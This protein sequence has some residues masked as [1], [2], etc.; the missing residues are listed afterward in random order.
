MKN[1]LDYPFDPDLVI[2]KKK[3]IK[4]ELLQ[5]V[6]FSD[7]K[8]AI[9][10]G[11]TTSEIKDILELFLLKE[12]IRPEL[13]ESEYNKYYEDIMFPN[14]RLEE[15]NPDLIYFHTTIVNIANFPDLTD[16]QKV[17]EE[18]INSVLSKFR[19]MWITAQKKYKAPIIQNNFELPHYRI[20]GNLDSSDSHGKT[21]FINI[22]NREFAKVAAENKS[23]YLNDIN[24]LSSWIGL[25]KWHDRLFWHS[26]KYAMGYTVIP[27]LSH[28]IASIIISIYGKSKK[29]L[30]LDL[31]N[32]LWGGIIGDDGLNGV[33]IGNETPSAEA[34]TEFQKYLKEIKDRGIILLVCS[35]NEDKNAKEGFNHPDTVLK[36][37][38]FTSFIANWDQKSENIKKVAKQINIGTQ[39]I[40]YIDDNPAEREIVRGNCPDVAVPEIGSDVL[41]FINIIDK[42]GYFE[43]VSISKDD[44]NRTSNYKDNAVRADYQMEFAD[45]GQFLAS[46]NMVAEIDT[47]QPVYMERITQL[48]NKTNQFNLTTKRYTAAE[49][50][51]VYQDPSYI[52]LY[53]KLEDKFGDSGL[54]SILVGKMIGRKK[55]HIDLWL[56]S[57][58]VIKRDMEFAMFDS[59]V[60]KC[61]EAGIETIYGIYYPTE[62]NG[63]VSK[64]FEV[65]GFELV[66]SN[67]K[68]DTSWR[69]AIPE[70]FKE[71]NKYIKVKNSK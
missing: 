47:F 6:N 37:E 57:C 68:G 1:I 58:R 34:Y 62:R 44:L 14:P 38:D 61:R 23:F 41:K 54:V 66:S 67:E 15:F 52:K 18:K 5:H 40:V 10:G 48:T 71:L 33:K 12:G 3:S 42:S 24:Y 26:Y 69:F 35:K 31:D 29:C 59:L 56:M 28:Q 65:L 2:R 60:K 50:D 8:I 70:T 22:L 13:Y 27:H 46:L 7:I 49:M 51:T 32:T 63:M 55:L 45:Y 25:E 64:L 39:S 17:I 20:L 30:T 9:L 43:P 4:K 19:N 16:S 36:L 21:Y 53:G 11:S